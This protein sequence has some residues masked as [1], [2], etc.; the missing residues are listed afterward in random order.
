MKS[1]FLIESAEIDAQPMIRITLGTRK[2]VFTLA[3]P[4]ADVRTAEGQETLRSWATSVAFL[5]GADV[6]F[7]TIEELL[8]IYDQRFPVPPTGLRRPRLRPW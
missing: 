7:H 3:M 6:P 8:D 5:P 2:R 1:Y 4:V